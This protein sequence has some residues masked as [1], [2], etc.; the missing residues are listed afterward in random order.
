MNG[1]AIRQLQKSLAESFTWTKLTNTP[2]KWGSEFDRICRQVGAKAPPTSWC[3]SVWDR[4]IS[5][6]VVQAKATNFGKTETGVPHYVAG[7]GIR[8][9]HESRVVP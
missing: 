2:S 6:V 9:T 4:A 7:W 1:L 5:S 3:E 8:N